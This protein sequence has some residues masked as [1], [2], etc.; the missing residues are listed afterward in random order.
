MKQSLKEHALEFATIAHQGQLR[1]GSG[2]PYITHPIAAAEI[3]LAKCDKVFEPFSTLEGDILYTVALL[4]DT[5][6]DVSWVDRHELYSRFGSIIADAVDALTKH[7]E[8]PYIN[9]VLRAK[10]NYFA[11]RVKWA[12]NEHNAYDLNPGTLLDKYR[13]SQYILTH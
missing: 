5:I 1:N 13:M 11:R 4:H 3:V 10:D 9:A 6:E 7:S 12:D 8:E 2:L